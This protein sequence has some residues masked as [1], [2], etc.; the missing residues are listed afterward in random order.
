VNHANAFF[1]RPGIIAWLQI[2]STKG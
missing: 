2:L 1:D